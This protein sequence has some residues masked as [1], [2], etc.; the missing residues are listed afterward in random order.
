MMMMNERSNDAAEGV[1]VNG[2]HCREHHCWCEL[3]LVT[4]TRKVH[5]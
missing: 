3:E 2:S 1:G 4:F 5:T